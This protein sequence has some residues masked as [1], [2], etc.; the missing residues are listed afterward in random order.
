MKVQRLRLT[1]DLCMMNFPM[2][3][4][5]YS[6]VAAAP[7]PAGLGDTKSWFDYYKSGAG[8]EVF[9]PFTAEQL[10]AKVLPNV[11]DALWFAMDGLIFGVARITDAMDDYV[12]GKV[13]VYYDSDHIVPV[14][15]SP[16]AL[17]CTGF[18]DD[19][20]TQAWCSAHLQGMV[21]DR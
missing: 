2:Q 12:T 11:G 7:A 19:Q 3:H 1:A 4:Y 18:V 10:P 17:P 13:E 5:I 9:V 21:V 8:P 6:M 20:A 16:D 15:D 14:L